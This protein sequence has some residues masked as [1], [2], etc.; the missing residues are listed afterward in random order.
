MRG[1]HNRVRRIAR[2]PQCGKV[3]VP[4]DDK[5]NGKFQTCRLAHARA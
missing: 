3:F 5:Q 2:C 4:T 1:N